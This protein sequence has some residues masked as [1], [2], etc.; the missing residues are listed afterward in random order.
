MQRQGECIVLAYA[1]GLSGLNVTQLGLL[2]CAVIRVTVRG[3][4]GQMAKWMDTF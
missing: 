1:A 3:N 2:I 4:R